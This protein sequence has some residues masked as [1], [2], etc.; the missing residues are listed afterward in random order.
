VS[1]QNQNRPME[2][3]ALAL[4][5]RLSAVS[6]QTNEN[7]SSNT[8]MNQENN[9]PAPTSAVSSTPVK[10]PAPAPTPPPAAAAAAV[11]DVNMSTPWEPCGVCLSPLPP[12]RGGSAP[13]PSAAVLE[14][15]CRHV[16]HYR[17]L[18]EAKRRKAQCPTC[19]CAL[20]PNT[21]AQETELLGYAIDASPSPQPPRVSTSS[22]AS[23]V[24]A[25]TGW[26]GGS[27]A[28]D[29]DQRLPL[30]PVAVGSAG[31]ENIARAAKRVRDALR[32]V[33]RFVRAG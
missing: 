8:G 1:H 6:L 22:A 7:S 18:L 27:G 4:A 14:T 11:A 2:D 5:D 25:R 33:P 17:C 23:V 3:E 29:G 10:G 32:C 15:R 9:A 20:T 31:R 28:D 13:P 30:P 16:F 12:R 24:T 21:A 19:R 26:G